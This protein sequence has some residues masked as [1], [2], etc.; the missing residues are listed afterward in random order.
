MII[1]VAVHVAVAIETSSSS[2]THLFLGGQRLLARRLLLYHSHDEREAS[3]VAM[4][5]SI[6]KKPSRRCDGGLCGV[7]KA[8]TL[9]LEVIW[10]AVILTKAN[11]DL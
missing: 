5:A 10:T 3:W 4:Q 6:T 8:E 11:T 1:V 7:T 2:R 9:T